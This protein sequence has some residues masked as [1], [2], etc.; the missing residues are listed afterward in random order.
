MRI[1][2]VEDDD[3]IGDSIRNWLERESY[4]VD[5]LTDGIDA[6]AALRAT[7]YDL[8][9]LDLGLPGR[10]GVVLLNEVRREENPVMVLVITARDQMEDRINTL[11]AGADDYLVKPFNLNELSA[12]VRALSRRRCGT[13]KPVLEIGNLCLNP[14]TH[15]VSLSGKRIHVTLREFTLLRILMEHPSKPFSREE[16]QHRLY[17]WDEAV[18]SNVIEHYISSLRRKL[19]TD[20]IHNMRGVGWMLHRQT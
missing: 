9:I 13:G 1:L 4:T 16:L 11:D 7:T 19:G 2:I 15:D 5:W 14:V 18:N 20:W 3:M 10:D 8:V 12:R 6:S 17:N